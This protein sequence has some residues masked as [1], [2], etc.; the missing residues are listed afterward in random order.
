MRCVLV[1]DEPLARERLRSLLAEAD[2]TVEIV[3]EAASGREAVPMIH[4]LK[5]EVVFLDVQMPVL[6]G[7]D[8][9]DLLARPRPHI[10]FVTAYDQY[11]I[12]AF[13]ARA[14]DYLTKPV[15]LER[16]RETL[17]RLPAEPTD[18]AL[19]GLRPDAPLERLAVHAGRRLRVVQIPDVQY[20]EARHKLVFARLNDGE[21]AVDATLESLERRLSGT[22]TRV[23][24]AYLVNLN[25][26][27]ELVPTRSGYQLRLTDG[28]PLPVA[29]RR[30]SNVRRLMS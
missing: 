19:D 26:I 17:R 29:R 24:R 1:D 9:V 11:A 2:A 14:I 27:R 18:G 30:A 6:D 22:F 23:H 28:T 3:G 15:R 8:V 10:V 7:F 20:F 4:E 25:A 5:P 21:F 13:D 12:R 16:L